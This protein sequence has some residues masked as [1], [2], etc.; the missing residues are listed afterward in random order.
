MTK[1]SIYIGLQ[2]G[3]IKKIT[4]GST[5]SEAK[6]TLSGLEVIKLTSN[7]YY[8]ITSVSGQ[9]SSEFGYGRVCAIMSTIGSASI[10]ALQA[11][12]THIMF[13]SRVLNSK[14]LS[15]DTSGSGNQ[16]LM[17][18]IPINFELGNQYKLVTILK[19]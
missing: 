4:A 3:F 16:R 19:K 11:S 12:N 6:K 8:Y 9:N 14:N 18:W 1:Q 7:S 2:D 10:N 5:I 13:G 17:C 15:F